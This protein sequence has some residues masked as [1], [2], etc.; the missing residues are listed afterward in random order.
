MLRLA[1]AFLILALSVMGAATYDITLYQSAYL[2]GTELK[3]GEYRLTVDGEKL[4][5]KNGKDS[6]EANVKVENLNEKVRST[7]LVLD[8]RGDKLQIV[9]VMLKGTSTRLVVR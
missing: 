4:V 3:A 9:A 2:G 8:Q 1:V 7:A 6:V 5:F